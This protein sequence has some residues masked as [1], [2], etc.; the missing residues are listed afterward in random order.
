V[1]N[2]Y[3]FLASDE[4]SYVTGATYFVDGGVT[5]SKSQAGEEVPSHLKQQPA[6][7]LRLSH[8]KEGHAEMRKEAAGTM[9]HGF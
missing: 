4:A 9:N 8:A 3:L 7:E 5:S 1:A 6:G 2:V